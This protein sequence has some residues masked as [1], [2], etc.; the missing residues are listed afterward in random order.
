MWGWWSSGY[1]RSLERNSAD[2]SGSEE[3]DA[4]NRTQDLQAVLIEFHVPRLAP[5]SSSRWDGEAHRAKLF[6]SSEAPTS[7]KRFSRRKRL[8][9]A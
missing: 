3:L 9:A 7:A 5:R 2:A 1:S 4:F 8:V 6:G